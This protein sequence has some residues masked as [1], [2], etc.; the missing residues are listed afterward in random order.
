MVWWTILNLVCNL[1]SNI[2]L[3]WASVIH[4]HSFVIK[5]S[6]VELNPRGGVFLMLRAVVI[7]KRLRI[8]RCVGSIM[9]KNPDRCH[10]VKR[11]KTENQEI[12]ANRWASRLKT[13]IR[14]IELVYEW[15]HD[16]KMSEFRMDSRMM[17]RWWS[18]RWLDV[19]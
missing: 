19:F 11:E 9:D 1:S 10:K 7:V 8:N 6:V 4:G 14:S 5:E 12:I 3:Y 16:G 13:K 2:L 18:N 15:L 17:E